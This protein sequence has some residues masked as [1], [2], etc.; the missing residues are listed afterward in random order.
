LGDNAELALIELVDFN[1]L[2]L[3]EAKPA[4]VKTRRSRRGAGTAAVET[5]VAAAPV[6]EVVETPVAEVAVEEVVAEAPVAEV[7][8]EETTPEAPEA[9]SEEKAEGEEQA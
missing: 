8:S 9:P 1:E 6:A 4:K 7:A 2:M 5:A 3:S